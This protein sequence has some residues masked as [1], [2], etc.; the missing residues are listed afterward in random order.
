MTTQPSPYLLVDTSY[1]VF[2]RYYA[3][4]QWYKK[5][6]PED[7]VKNVEDILE[8]PVFMEKYNH[9]FFT[10]LEKL[11]KQYAIRD[12]RRVIFMRD[13]PSANIWRREFYKEY[14][15][16]RDYS[17][18]NGKS[19]FAYTYDNVLS[20]WTAKGAKV[21]RFDTLE[22][23][24]IGAVIA[25]EYT[26]RCGGGGVANTQKMLVMIT[27]DNDYLQLRKYATVELVN[28]KGEYLAERS[29][30]SP[31][32]DLQCKIFLGDPS[33]NI[34][35]VFPRCGEKTLMK[36][37]EDPE[38]MTAEFA[39]HPESRSQYELNT[40]LVDFECIPE[41]LY[42]CVVAWMDAGNMSLGL[43]SFFR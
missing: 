18:F 35:K 2:Y 3:M 7:D 9:T 38:R 30:G 15:S 14:K 22:A 8:K 10:S 27:N 17:A 31:E 1:V 28:L 32:L 37:L 26:K 11:M 16:N 24:D 6:Y 34:P 29:R 36:L 4:C 33:D 12:F 41:E 25:K 19:I 40:K 42:Q 13:C 5:A 39:K 21:V 20:L 23:D 43:R